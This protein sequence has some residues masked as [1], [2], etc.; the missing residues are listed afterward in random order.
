MLKKT[1]KKIKKRIYLQKKY[2]FKIS[3]LKIF[4]GFENALNDL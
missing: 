3:T 2:F 4:L 1:I